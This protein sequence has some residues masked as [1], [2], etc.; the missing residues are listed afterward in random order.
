MAGTTTKMGIQ[1]PTSTDLV[2]DGATAMQTLATDVDNKSGLVFIKSQTVGTAVSSV[3][4]SSAFSATF[5]NYRIVYSSGTAST[6]SELR[7]RLGSTTTGYYMGGS[8]TG[9]TAGAAV[10][11]MGTGNVAQ[12][13]FVGLGDPNG[14]FLVCDLYR[15]NIA[16]RTGVIVP[17]TGLSTARVGG[18][19]GGFLDNATSYTAFTLLTSTGTLTG[20]TIRVYGYNQ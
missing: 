10:T 7:M 11:S 13:T 6:F 20:G 16:G 17:V 14:N 18:A 3:T 9:F 1:Y 4:V 12:W 2:K 5:D 8:W 19:G 15:P